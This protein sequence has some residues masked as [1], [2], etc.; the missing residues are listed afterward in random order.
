MKLA[1]K[2]L[3]RRILRAHPKVLIQDWY[4]DAQSRAQVKS[5]VEKVL[6][7]T[8]P[9]SYDRVIFHAK[10]DNVFE[11]IYDYASKGEKWAA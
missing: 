6:H 1:A 7:E 2:S 8:L 5:T 10:C 9:D 4:K 3:L 11:L